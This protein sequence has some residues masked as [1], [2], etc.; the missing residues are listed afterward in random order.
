MR[1]VLRASSSRRIIAEGLSHAWQCP[2]VGETP[3]DVGKGNNCQP[4]HAR[5]KGNNSRVRPHASW[6]LSVSEG[7]CKQVGKTN[8]RELTHKFRVDLQ[9]L[10]NK[11]ANRRCLTP[12]GER[13]DGRA[14]F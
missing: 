4:T 11:S 1:I 9:A 7:T 13:L 12:A 10:T 3:D 2:R 8:A 14:R 5:V 6:S